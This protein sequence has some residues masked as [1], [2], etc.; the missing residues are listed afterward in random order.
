MVPFWLLK[1]CFRYV[2]SK[3]DKNVE[4]GMT[5]KLQLSL[6]IPQNSLKIIVNFIQAKQGLDY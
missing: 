6:K 5:F 2:F 1:K 4:D 3:Q